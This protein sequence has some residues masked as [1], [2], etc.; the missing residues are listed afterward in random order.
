VRLHLHSTHHL[1]Q[2][3]LLLL[4]CQ[5]VACLLLPPQPLLPCQA[6]LVP[7]AAVQSA[8]LSGMQCCAEYAFPQVQHVGL[9]ALLPA[10]AWAVLAAVAAAA[11]VSPAA[12]AAGESH[13]LCCGQRKAV[14]L[15]LLLLLLPTVR[16]PAAA[17]A[18]QRAAGAV[19]GH[20]RLSWDLL[21]QEGS[22]AAAVR[23]SCA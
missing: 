4:H 12:A 19:K 14:L 18:V 15:L 21:L 23:P 6:A 5:G 22:A 13:A 7:A 1:Q 11:V 2:Q 20:A 8:Q 9:A 16:C 3:Q 17:G 10:A